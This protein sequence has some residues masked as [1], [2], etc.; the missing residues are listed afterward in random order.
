MRN[1][2][3]RINELKQISGFKDVRWRRLIE[4]YPSQ[5]VEEAKLEA[6]LPDDCP[7]IFRT[8]IEPNHLYDENR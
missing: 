8:F 7:V 1:H 4:R 6:G 5:S 2:E 3:K